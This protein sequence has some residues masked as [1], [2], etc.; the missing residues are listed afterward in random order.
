MAFPG[1]TAA[2]I[3]DAILNRAPTPLTQANPN[4]APELERI[5]NKGLEKDRSSDTKVPPTFA[6]TCND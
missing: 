1:N 2:V 4:S 6:P 5:V 3:H